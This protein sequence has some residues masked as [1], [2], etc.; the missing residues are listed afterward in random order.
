MRR[1]VLAVDI[2]AQAVAIV[3]TGASAV[4]EGVATKLLGD[5]ISDRLH[6]NGYGQAWSEFQRDPKNDSLVRHLLTEALRQDT[7]FRMQL[8]RAVRAAAAEVRGSS[9]PQAVTVTGSS[10]VQVG[11]RG[12]Q[13][14]GGRVATRGGIYQEG[15]HIR[16]QSKTV[17]KNGGAMVGVVVLVVLAL[18]LFIGVKVISGLV[19]SSQNAGLTAGSTCQQFLNTDEDDERQAL[20]DIGESYGFSVYSSPLALPEI[21]Y[22]CGS[23]PTM[24]LGELIQRDG[25]NA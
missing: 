4:A 18:L 10:N 13:I 6:R 14:T 23:V 17:K 2:A 9:M 7:E 20:A 16:N 5:L 12:D 15:K 3:A 25:N 11:N 1:G 24:T 21:Q 8:E 22:E 19:K